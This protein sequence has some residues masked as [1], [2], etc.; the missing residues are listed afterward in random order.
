MPAQTVEHIEVARS[1]FQKQGKNN[2]YR[3]RELVPAS[4]SSKSV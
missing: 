2:F 4:F 3:R 1:T